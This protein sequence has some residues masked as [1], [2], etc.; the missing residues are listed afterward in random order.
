LDGAGWAELLAALGS[1]ALLA[2]TGLAAG[3]RAR[4]LATDF[5]LFLV[6]DFVVLLFPRCGMLV[7]SLVG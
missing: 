7:L 6:L 2:A 1:G 4:P 5:V 3:L